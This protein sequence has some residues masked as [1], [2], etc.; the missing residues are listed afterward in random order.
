M[1]LKQYGVT[2][3]SLGI[4]EVLIPTAI[5]IAGIFVSY[6]LFYRRNYSS[7]DEQSIA[8]KILYNNRAV[9]KFYLCIAKSFSEF[10][11]AVDA[12]YNAIYNVAKEGARNVGAFG[13]LIKRVE[14]G[15][16]TIYVAAFIVGLMIIVA[17]F[18][19]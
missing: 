11:K 16:T 1:Y 5:I 14:T 18:V 19:L 13:D 12:V 3:F 10:S 15:K 6:W 8:Q 17:I 9:N 2:P 7:L 4:A